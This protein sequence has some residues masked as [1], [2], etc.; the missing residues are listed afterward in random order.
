[1]LIWKQF[2]EAFRA[3]LRQNVQLIIIPTFWTLLDA[4]PQVLKL[5]PKSESLFLDSILT[6]RAFENTCAVVF[7]NAGGKEDDGFAGMSQI[8]M[9]VLGKVCEAD[10]ARE[11]VVMGLVETE[12]LE[13]A[14]K[15][16]RIRRDLER[17]DEVY[18]AIGKSKI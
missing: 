13:E 10:G 2:N 7:C 5:N 11:Q 8:T 17:V 18:G 12:V 6:A 15:C 4:T 1:M 14:E 3:L 16:Y 9:P